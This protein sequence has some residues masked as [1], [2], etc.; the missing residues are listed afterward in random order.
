MKAAARG[1][2][3][4]AGLVAGS[5]KEKPVPQSGLDKPWD[6]FGKMSCFV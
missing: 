5:K 1:E 2:L 6:C 3:G 4:F